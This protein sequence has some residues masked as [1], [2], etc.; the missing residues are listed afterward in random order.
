MN[1]GLQLPGNWSVRAKST[2][3]IDARRATRRKIFGEQRDGDHERAGCGHRD[4]VT[5]LD[6][7]EIAANG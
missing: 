4:H 6:A 7:E 3:R 2:D 1:G 5:R